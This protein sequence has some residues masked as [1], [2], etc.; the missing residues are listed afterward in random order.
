[1]LF[2]GAAVVVAG[3]LLGRR[4]PA[5]RWLLVVWESIAFVIT[6]LAVTGTWFGLGLVAVPIV[7]A[8]GIPL[9]PEVLVLAI[10]AVLV[11]ALAVHP[12]THRAFAR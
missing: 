8:G 12:A 10:E 5:A 4:S 2:I 3:V 11:Y 9:L 7:A 1:M 6:L